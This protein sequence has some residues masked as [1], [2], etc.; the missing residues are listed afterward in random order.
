MPILW[1]WMGQVGFHTHVYILWSRM[2]WMQARW[3]KDVGQ[4]C[5]ILKNHLKHRIKCSTWGKSILQQND[6]L[7]GTSATPLKTFFCCWNFSKQFNPNCSTRVIQTDFLLLLWWGDH[8]CFTLSTGI[9]S[10]LYATSRGK[11]AN[12]FSKS[13]PRIFTPCAVLTS[14]CF[15]YWF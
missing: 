1:W 12:V 3:T 15:S 6:T 5:F 4:L 9:S 7:K 2:Q 14:L 11:P 10:S 13:F 8:T